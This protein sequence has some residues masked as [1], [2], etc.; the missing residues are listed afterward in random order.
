MSPLPIRYLTPHQISFRPTPRPTIPPLFI[1][2]ARIKPG[3]SSPGSTQTRPVSE[4]HLWFSP[5]SFLPSFPFSLLFSGSPLKSCA[6]SSFGFSHQDQPIVVGPPFHIHFSLIHSSFRSTQQLKN[7]LKKNL[8]VF[9]FS[10]LAL[11]IYFFF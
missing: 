7:F 1:S 5:P 9:F 8:H 4:P 3:T 10:S 6:P 2:R 11:Y